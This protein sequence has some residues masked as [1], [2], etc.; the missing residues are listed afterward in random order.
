MMEIFREAATGITNRYI[1]DWT[2]S[3][4][5][6]VGYTCSFM[7][8]EIFHAADILPYRIRGIETES[9]EIGD[10]YYGPFVC[11]FPKCLLQLAGEGK[12]NFLNGAVVSTGCDA[13]RRLDECWRK[14]G[15]DFKGALPEFFH[16]FDVPHKTEPHALKWFENEISKL[17]SSVESHF[18]VSIT[19]QKLKK[20]IKIYN[21]GRKLLWKLEELRASKNLIISGEDAFSVAVAGTV[22]PREIFNEKLENLLK[23]LSSQNRKAV[24]TKKRIMVAGSI[25]DDIEL[26]K[27]IEDAGSTVVSDSICF[28]IRSET[29]QVDTKEKPVT[30]LAKRYLSNS[31]CPR[32]FGAYQQRFDFLK[33]KAERAGVEGIILQNI[34][35]CD[36]HGSENGLFEKDFEKMGIPCLRLE[37]EYGPLTE[38]GRMKMRIEAFFERIS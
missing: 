22:M 19:E 33:E 24:K 36:L 17:I 35:F 9:M 18:N 12:F 28:G 7:P 3:G 37:R 4:K 38:T 1:S 11:T 15:E 25:N 29:D 6:I 26:V 23:K 27:L 16:Y 2:K 30:A 14:A 10:A 21:H 32:M 20:A 5:K 31:V 34:R 13:M 8:P